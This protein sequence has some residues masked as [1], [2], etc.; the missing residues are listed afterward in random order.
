M[1]LNTMF[2]APLTRAV[3]YL[4]ELSAMPSIIRGSELRTAH[5]VVSSSC[6][7]LEVPSTLCAMLVS[8]LLQPVSTST[9]STTASAKARIRFVLLMF[10]ILKNSKSEHAIS[11]HDTIVYRIFFRLTRE[12]V[13]LSRPK[14]P[15]RRVRRRRN[16]PHR[17]RT[18]NHSGRAPSPRPRHCADRTPALPARCRC[19]TG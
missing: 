8:V 10:Y 13:R 2:S 16:P 14:P 9:A 5:W 1:P 18:G 19:T 11:L 6:T 7:S 3:A 4:A 15:A 12:F 17:A